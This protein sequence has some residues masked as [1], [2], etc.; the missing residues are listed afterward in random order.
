MLAN[1][2]SNL[3]IMRN[4]KCCR[5]GSGSGN[6]DSGRGGLAALTS[7][8]E[9][10]LRREHGA[11]IGRNSG[12]SDVEAKG[13]VLVKIGKCKGPE[14]RLRLAPAENGWCAPVAGRG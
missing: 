3:E 9:A 10:S 14:A 4:S 11:E 13:S 2:F 1:T 12:S 8:W 5:E 6:G 7:H